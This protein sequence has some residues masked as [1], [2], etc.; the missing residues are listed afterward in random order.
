MRGS[1][2]ALLALALIGATV[3]ASF[4]PSSASAAGTSE[5][6]PVYFPETGHVAGYGFLA[7]WQHFGG[8]AVFGYPL[9]NEFHGCD[10]QGWCGT[11]QYFQ[12]ALFEWHPGSDAAR[13]DVELAL[14]GDQL[15]SKLQGEPQFQPGSPLAPGAS[16]V[17]FQTHHTLCD[18]DGFLPYWRQFGGLLTFGYPISEPFGGCDPQGW[19]GTMQWFQR[20]LFE[21][22]PGS[23]PTRY[24]VELGLVGT[25]ALAT[26]PASTTSSTAN[27]VL[28]IPNSLGARGSDAW[29]LTS[30]RFLLTTDGGVHWSSTP[31]PPGVEPASD[32]VPN[33]LTNA[34]VS[35]SGALWLM[36]STSPT[37]ATFYQA[38][39]PNRPWVKTS[40]TLNWSTNVPSGHGPD[41]TMLGSS[42]DGIISAVVTEGNPEQPPASLFLISADNGK[43][44]KQYDPPT[45]T[46]DW[47]W[48]AFTSASSG[49]IGNYGGIDYTTDGGASWH[50]S[51]LPG[52]T[53]NADSILGSPIIDGSRIYVVTNLPA[54]GGTGLQLYVSDNGGVTFVEMKSVTVSSRY[55]SSGLSALGVSGSNVWM[56][57]FPISNNEVVTPDSGTI[58]EST[59]GGATWKT[60]TA[61]AFSNPPTTATANVNKTLNSVA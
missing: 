30:T 32:T 11:M 44:F 37:T 59:D 33:P 8:V 28:G 5:P 9:T 49:V 48:T 43:T 54:S 53:S 26:Q 34:S 20:S 15:T 3:F 16:C 38:A 6:S 13:Y 14:L 12:R 1:I 52:Y 51:T 18:A 7:F 40:I 19:C 29:A 39:G 61:P 45:L 46:G 55:Y 60:V 22:H 47:Q 35:P 24:D 42:A 2:T 4:S 17:T 57:P 21:Y 41:E 56:I 50:P 58:F 31:L 10:P 36:L 27:A 23:N 25:A